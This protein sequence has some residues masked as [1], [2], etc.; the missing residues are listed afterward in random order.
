MFLSMRQ[1][2]LSQKNIAIVLFFVF[3]KYYCVFL[4]QII[5][6]E[7]KYAYFVFFYCI[8]NIVVIFI[9]KRNFYFFPTKVS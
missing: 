4:L 5:N 3:K 1:F 8:Q 6:K 9:I 2:Y 7:N